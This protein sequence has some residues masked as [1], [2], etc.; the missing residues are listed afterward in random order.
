MSEVK[1]LIISVGRPIDPLIKAIQHHKPNFVSF[2][3]SQDTLENISKVI[4]ALK[5]TGQVF[6]SETT[7]TDNVDD[8]VICHNKAGEAVRRVLDKGYK[9]SQVVTDY[10]FGTKNMAVALALAA[11]D[12]GF[13]FSYVGGTQRTN[14]GIGTV[15]SGHEH[16][17][18]SVN[19]W[20]FLAVVERSKA[21]LFFNTCQFKAC[22]DLLVDLT[23]KTTQRRTVYKKLSNLVE[24]FLNWDLFRHQDGLMSFKASRL[25]DLEEDQDQRIASFAVACGKLRPRL[26]SILKCSG[27]G[28]LPCLP[29]ALDLFANAERR[30]IEGMVD[31]AILRLYRVVEMLA[32]GRLLDGYNINAGDVTQEQLPETIRE[33]YMQHY[34]NDRDNKIKLPQYAAYGLLESLGDPLGLRFAAEEKRFLG[35]Q[36]ARNYSYLAHGFQSAK[37]DTYRS[38]RKFVMNLGS[39]GE[40][41]IIVF[42]TLEL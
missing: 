15:E 7:L 11:I 2:F 30:F 29:L 33:K 10:T 8:L 27:Q 38:L 5:K 40:E 4:D 14:D 21:S 41:D 3:A 35:I 20:D 23:Q 17:Y 6:T 34:L 31:D 12:C 39:I 36:Q 1:A 9:R 16:V 19:P 24:A 13:T 18:E 26:D 22:R 25:D 42:P 28:K 37:E 32:Q